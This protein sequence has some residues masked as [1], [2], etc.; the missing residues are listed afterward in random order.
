M[1]A[2]LGF[3]HTARPNIE[4]FARL[5]A[6][7][8]PAVPTQ[9]SL[10]D[11]VLADA[12]GSG[13]VT[14]NMRETTDRAIRTLVEEGAGLILCTCSTIGGVAESTKSAGSIPVLRIDRPMAEAAVASGRRL[15]VAAA[16][17][18]TLLPTTALLHQ[19]ASDA[20]RSID[21]VELLCADAWPHYQRGDHPAY[22]SSIA[23]TVATT[24][25]GTDVV[26]LAQASMAPAVALIE[27]NGIRALA[28]PELGVRTAMA[29]YRSSNQAG[30]S[31]G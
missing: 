5:A 6:G 26:V 30:R 15:I 14:D 13:A 1:P 11:S 2:F 27:A 16:L 8:D 3:L 21:V 23:A 31:A 12:V 24:A 22:A 25:R 28:S 19:V 4:V 29:L 18:S 10:I 17:P 7:I 9:H 20:G